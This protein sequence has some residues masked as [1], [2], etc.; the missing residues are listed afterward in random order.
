MR[1]QWT[2][3]DDIH[4]SYFHTVSAEYLKASL[5]KDGLPVRL[6]A[7]DRG[8]EHHPRCSRRA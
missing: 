4:C 2:R 5:N 6:V 1:V 8:A 7:P 3:E